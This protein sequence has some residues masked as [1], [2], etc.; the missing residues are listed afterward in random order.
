MKAFHRHA[1]SL[2][3]VSKMNFIRGTDLGNNE[4]QIRG[5]ANFLLFDFH[6]NTFWVDTFAR[7]SAN[8]RPHAWALIIKQ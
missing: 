3:Y 6:M 2:D 4:D 1:E 8:V 7:V 5:S